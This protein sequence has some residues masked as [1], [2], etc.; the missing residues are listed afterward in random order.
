M[1][2]KTWESIPEDKRPLPNRLNVILSKNK[3]Y[4]PKCKERDGTPAPIVC[5]S[6][7][8]AINII[9]EMYAVAETFI[10]GG[11]S[12]YEEALSDHMRHLCKLIIATRIN[13]DFEAD[14]F[15]PAFEEKFEPIF[16]S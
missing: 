3:D 6:L 7:G 13:K 16:I 4:E 11:Q 5:P 12:V 9:N 14:V 1:G 15:M 2:R 10:I 8:D